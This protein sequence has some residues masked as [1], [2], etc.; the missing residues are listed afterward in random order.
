MN[1]KRE[2]AEHEEWEM[3]VEKISREFEFPETPQ[4]SEQIQQELRPKPSLILRPAALLVFLAL[5]GLL[6]A[7]PQI[8]AAVVEY[9]RLGA[10]NFMLV[11]TLTP[12]P[13]LSVVPLQT[14]IEVSLEDA[15]AAVAFAV[16][17]PAELDSPSVVYLQQMELP[18]VVLVWYEPEG[19]ETSRILL[20]IIDSRDSFFKFTPV[21]PENVS[22]DGHTGAWFEYPHLMEYFEDG[23]RPVSRPVEGNVLVWTANNLTYRLEG[24]LT[25][26]EALVIAESMP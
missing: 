3:T 7:V 6:F 16:D 17:I 12:F 11:P 15:Q 4:I 20:Y 2:M 19:Y 1:D 18:M 26:E 10:G 14:G 8:R 9:I 23:S 24:E 22:V 25:L 21:D 5:L 13:T